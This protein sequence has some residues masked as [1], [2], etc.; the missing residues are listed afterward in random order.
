MITAR[1]E[2]SDIEPVYYLPYETD[3]AEKNIA[4]GYYYTAM[5]NDGQIISVTPDRSIL[6]RLYAF[7]EDCID[8]LSESQL[9]A[10]A[11]VF[12]ATALMGSQEWNDQ[13]MRD[14]LSHTG[15]A[16]ILALSGLH[17]SIIA[18][19]VL[20]LLTP[21]AL[22][23]WRHVHRLAA[24]ALLWLFAVMTGLS[25]SVTRAVIMMTIMLG[26]DIIERRSTT[27][28]ALC[29]A[30]LVILIASPQ[31]LF[32]V[33]FQLS[34]AS[35]AGIAL[36]AGKLS[37]AE[38]LPQ[39]SSRSPIA[40]IGRIILSAIAVSVVTMLCSGW[41]IAYHFHSLPTYF[42]IANI[43]VV[44][45]IVP[46][47]ISGGIGVIILNAIGIPSGLLCGL[48]NRSVDMLNSWADCLASLPGAEISTGRIS[49]LTLLAALMLILT[50][51]L[52]M[53]ERRANRTLPAIMVSAAL[54]LTAMSCCFEANRA[55]EGESG[56]WYITA[57]GTATE[58][59][60]NTPQALA[61]VSTSRINP[62]DR[63]HIRQRALAR[64]IR[65]MHSRRLDS[66]VVCDREA[67]LPGLIVNRGVISTPRG[68]VLLLSDNMPGVSPNQ[69]TKVD[70][71]VICRGFRGDIGEM[72]RLWR[73]AKVALSPDLPPKMREKFAADCLRAGVT[74]LTGPVNYL[75][76]KL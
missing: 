13:Q 42:I 43:P 25:P 1:C 32:S 45:F 75:T 51:R 38:I 15:L 64:Y 3:P 58:L 56:E 61:I 49:L 6:G 7:R 68:S 63:E 62:H 5:V 52:V 12:L 4:A 17:T 60:V 28:N 59:V 70:L 72:I 54:L 31:A 67:N 50:L 19:M 16:H 46:V 20:V 33:S 37:P 55:P 65:Y 76:F 9:S 44:P 36:F 10:Q 8:I 2:F 18:M 40:K 22:V 30:A 21:L 39:S 29:I 26:G 53:R 35:V 73:P 27:L 11:K 23:T 34:F 14:N 48:V 66:V 24:I 57:N 47:I 74:P 71:A 69:Q 41:L